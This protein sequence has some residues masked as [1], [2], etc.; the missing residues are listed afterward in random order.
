MLHTALRVGANGV[1]RM[2]LRKGTCERV[3]EL[4]THL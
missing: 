4:V 3:P 2:K 1:V